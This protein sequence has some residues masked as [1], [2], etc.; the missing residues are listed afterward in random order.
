MKLKLL[1]ENSD[2]THAGFVQWIKQTGQ[3]PKEMIQSLMQNPPDH[4]GGNASFWYIPNSVFGLL[5]QRSGFKKAG[6]GDV[7]DPGDI[8]PNLNV[9]QSI[10]Q[11]G[12]NVSIVKI[13]KGAP[14][15]MKHRYNRLPKEEQSQEAQNYKNKLKQ[16]AN[17]PIEAYH[18][19]FADI[20]IIMSKG[21]II[22]PSKP[23]NLLISD[24]GFGFV[25][26]NDRTK[27]DKG[28]PDVDLIG[29]WVLHMFIQYSEIRK[30]LKDDPEAIKYASN[31]VSKI[32]SASKAAGFLN[33]AKGNEDIYTLVGLDKPA[34]APA[35]VS[36]RQD[37]NASKKPAQ[38]PSR[39][40]RPGETGQWSSGRQARGVR[41]GETGQW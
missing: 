4:R 38:R 27:K 29:G 35:P 10:A 41:P 21:K 25:D 17:M 12:P 6:V 23:G 39:G 3:N 11:F 36:D 30:F 7:S 5:V 1:F 26:L 8:F 34:P 37:I 2:N 15:G 33:V 14:S 9:G 24:N 18:K 28:R 13:Q 22:D 19:M 32:T 40:V 16:C 20:K 31:I